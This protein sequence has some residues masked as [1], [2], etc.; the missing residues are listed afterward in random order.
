MRNNWPFTRASV[1]HQIDVLVAMLRKGIDP[2]RTY[3]FWDD[4]EPMLVTAREI[5]AGD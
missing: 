1:R 4:P 3:Y 5:A 2:E